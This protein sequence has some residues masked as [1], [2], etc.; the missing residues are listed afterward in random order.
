MEFRVLGPVGVHSDGGVQV[1]LGGPRPRAVLA[2]LLLAQGAVVSADTLIDDLY[3]GAPPA[4]ALSSLHSYV[5]NLRRIIEPGRSPR[6]PPLLPET[7]N[8]G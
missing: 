4:S 8:R 3:S 1:D 2:R 6:T 7:R 5:S